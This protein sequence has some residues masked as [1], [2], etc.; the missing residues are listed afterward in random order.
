[1][2][3]ETETGYIIEKFNE[4]KLSADIN[5]ITAKKGIILIKTPPYDKVDKASLENYGKEES[6]KNLKLS[7]LKQKLSAY[8]AKL[9]ILWDAGF[10]N[11]IKVQVELISP[12][13]VDD[14]AKKSKEAVILYDRAVENFEF[15]AGKPDWWTALAK[16]S[17]NQLSADYFFFKAQSN[18]TQGKIDK[19]NQFIP[20]TTNPNLET[21][22]TARVA[23]E[24]AKKTVIDTKVGQ[25]NEVSTAK[26]VTVTTPSDGST[27]KDVRTS[28]T[29]A[30]AQFV[31]QPAIGFT[32]LSEFTTLSLQL[33]PSATGDNL[34]PAVSN[35]VKTFFVAENPLGIQLAETQL[36]EGDLF[37]PRKTQLFMPN[38]NLGGHSAYF[39]MISE[40]GFAQTTFEQ[41]AKFDANGKII[42]GTGKNIV[43]NNTLPPYPDKDSDPF[44]NG[45]AIYNQF[46]L[47]TVNFSMNEKM[48][49]ED[50]FSEGQA[51]FVFGKAP[52]TW[53]F[54]GTLINDLYHAWFPKFMDLW[55]N[56]IRASQLVRKKK[57]L[58][59]VVPSASAI[60]E[61]YP[62]GF[63]AVH[64]V[65][66]E[67]NTPFSIVAYI[68][69]SRQ[70]PNMAVRLAND[71][72][73]LNKLNPRY[74]I[75]QM[76][77]IAQEM[78]DPNVIQVLERD[79][80]IQTL[81]QQIVDLRAFAVANPD[82]AIGI[83]KQ[84]E[85][86]TAQII[87]LKGNGVI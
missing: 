41:Q 54:S 39:Y 58:V 69:S 74:T 35:A 61:C 40:D 6:A 25:I 3:I 1:M 10:V 30:E 13:R 42:P 8:E 28:Q 16:K 80:S 31:N 9:T 36:V 22:L 5:I 20:S 19:I 18:T 43:N 38:F 29:F 21:A 87:V 59:L 76:G 62:R 51:T 15:R 11:Y 77:K 37:D 60:I 24:T 86:I 47:T 73:N 17:P 50:T 53:V 44:K 12:S 65:E 52:Y 48:Q 81:E 4:K 84:I 70:F 64:S 33:T 78:Q 14:D 7:D 26:N 63:S 32:G 82:Q 71:S 68:R 66:S 83:L 56:H 72:G 85:Q 45:S 57:I 2:A 27:G 75:N 55:D 34:S 46:S 23:E 79:R 49:I 67:T